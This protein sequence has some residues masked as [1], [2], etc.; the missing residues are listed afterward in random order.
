[1]ASRKPPPTPASRQ[2]SA[3]ELKRLI[4]KINKRIAELKEFDL[5]TIVGRADPPVEALRLKINSTLLDSLGDGTP[6]ERTYHIT[7]LN[8]APMIMGVQ[9]SRQTLIF[10]A[11][12]G[13][14]RAIAKLQGL[15]EV[16]AERLDDLE[17]TQAAAPAEAR[18]ARPVGRK[19]F[20]VHGHDDVARL[21]VE[22]F[23]KKLN[24][25]PIILHDQ[26]NGGRTIVEKLEGYSDV[27]FAVILLTPDDEGREVASGTTG[28]LLPRARQNVVLELGLF[29]GLLGRGKVCAL[30]KGALELPSDFQGVLYTPLDAAGGWHLALARE[31]RAAGLDVD[32]NLAM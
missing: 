11:Q 23:L 7:S 4:V 24:F 20:V 19:V 25:D 28:P 5:N 14:E 15:A 18:K 31:L 12:E 13:F 1:M 30:H 32:M 22:R 8:T 9:Q 29:F 6:E 10:G 26:A 16:L 27:D 2:L 21:E 17:G 3:E